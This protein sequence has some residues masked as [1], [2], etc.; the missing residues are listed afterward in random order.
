MRNETHHIVVDL[1]HLVLLVVAVIVM[2]MMVD[3][4]LVTRMETRQILGGSGCFG[5]TARSAAVLQLQFQIE[6]IGHRVD[7]VTRVLYFISFFRTFC[8]CVLMRVFCSL[9]VVFCNMVLFRFTAW[10]LCVCHFA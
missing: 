10:N 5:R 1:D 8:L 9:L 7:C 6:Q 4:H 2:D 3:V